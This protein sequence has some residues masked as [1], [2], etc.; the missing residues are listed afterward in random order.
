MT[1]KEKVYGGALYD[2][3][4]E[5]GVSEVVLHQLRQ[6]VAIFDENPDY[7]R[8]L[9]TVSITK[10][11]RCAALDEAL[12][13][14][15]EPYLLNFVKILCENGAASQLRG[16]AEE[17]RA[18]YYEDHNIVQV[19]AVTAVEMSEAMAEK[20]C[21]K[22]QSVLGKTVELSCKM[23][24]GC[25]GGVLLRLPDRQYD[26]TVRQRLDAL[27]AQLKASAM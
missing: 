20:L 14:K 11:E 17:Y 23:D 2:L 18:R 19:Q 5:E 21:G 24:P 25:M 15:V 26:G 12:G 9:D 16:C 1:K 8:F 13:G 10:C 22:L 6:V 3:C 4:R 27:R 7:W